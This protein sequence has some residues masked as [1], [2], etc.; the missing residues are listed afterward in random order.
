M[1]SL[2]SAAADTAR[3]NLFPRFAQMQR[4][5]EE[6][7]IPFDTMINA[8]DGLHQTDWSTNCVT[9]ALFW[10]IELAVMAEIVA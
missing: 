8:A 2:I 4:W 1:V 6:D 7:G 5:H 10:A 9:K 3:V